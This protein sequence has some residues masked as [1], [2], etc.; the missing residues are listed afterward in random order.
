VPERF[1]HT[2]WIV[3]ESI[4]VL[5]Q[6]DPEN[7]FFLWM[8]FEA[9]HSPFDPPQ[10]YDRMY[11]NF[12]IPDPVQAG[13]VS[14]PGYPPALQLDRTVRK[15][16]QLSPE[17]IRESRRRYYGQISHID[18]QLA[19]FFGELK[20]LGLYDDTILV[21][22]SDHGEQLGDHGLFGKYTFLNASCRLPLIA[23]FPAQIESIRP[24]TVIDAPV[25][26][27]DLFPTLLALA[28]GSYDPA[29]IDGTSLV[30]A[31][32][33]QESLTGR[34]ICGEVNHSAFATDGRYKYIYYLQGGVEQ[35][36]DVQADPDDLHNLAGAGHVSAVQARLKR[37]LVAYL[38]R[39]QRP[40]VQGGQLSLLPAEIDL[41]AARARNDMAWRGPMR[42]GRGY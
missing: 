14:D 6:R 21:F 27:A 1:T 40:S 3:D 9:P 10:P 5:G 34:V 25:Q 18:H 38:T 30:G 19:R 20:T 4:N 37:E 36:F 13:W 33:G 15:Y 29:E 12:T 41:A 42:F 22:T 23:R 16:D 35:V 32:S 39:H 8:V 11:D 26:T 2:H 28:G 7:P 17:V 24:G 31:L